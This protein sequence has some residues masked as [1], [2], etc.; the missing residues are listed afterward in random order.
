MKFAL[1][2]VLALL[3]PVLGC[4]SSRAEKRPEAAARAVEREPTPERDW[5]S[6]IQFQNSSRYWMNIQYLMVIR[7]VDGSAYERWATVHVPPKVG[8]RNGSVTTGAYHYVSGAEDRLVQV[9]PTQ[10]L[11]DER[12]KLDSEEWCHGL[13]EWKFV[14]HWAGHPPP[15]VRNQPFAAQVSSPL[16]RSS[17]QG[18]D[19]QVLATQAVALAKRHAESEARWGTQKGQG[20]QFTLDCFA[21]TGNPPVVFEA[22]WE[23]PTLEAFRDAAGVRYASA[24]ISGKVKLKCS[25]ERRR[26]SVLPD[27]DADGRGDPGDE[28]LDVAAETSYR[29]NTPDDGDCEICF[30]DL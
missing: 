5:V 18:D 27:R 11:I 22:A 30:C 15:D 14:L 12:V 8:A 28:Y 10:Y 25:E 13:R 7:R 26:S 29:D 23:P 1:L 17:G 21:R 16:Q 19:D 24:A 3:P 4:K 20:R 6:S 9:N 2:S